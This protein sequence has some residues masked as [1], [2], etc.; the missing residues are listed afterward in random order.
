VLVLDDGSIFTL[1]TDYVVGRDPSRDERVLA[2]TARPLRLDDPQGLI[3]RAH[4][5]IHLEGWQVQVIDLG[6]ANGT[7]VFAPGD[8]AW[9][10]TPR[11][12]PVTIRPGTQ[13]GFGQRQLR[14][15]SHTNT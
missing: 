1:Q 12:T 10:A 8:S 5:Q 2:G 9:Q 13:I 7:G 6:S 14:F 11:L 15:E 3:S 4:F